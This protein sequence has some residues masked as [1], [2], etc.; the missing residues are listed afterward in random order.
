MDTF[1]SERRLMHALPYG[2]QYHFARNDFHLHQWQLGQISVGMTGE[3][4]GWTNMLMAFSLHDKAS[5]HKGLVC[6]IGISVE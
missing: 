3:D 6:A 1:L 4:D 2:G 5:V